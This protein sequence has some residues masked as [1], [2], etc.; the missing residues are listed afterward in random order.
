MSLPKNFLWG[1]AVAAH[2]IEGGLKETSKGVS[3]AD[4]VTGGSNIQPRIITDGIIEGLY[5]PDHIAIDFYHHYKE[6]IALF[7]EMG[8]KCFRT[9]IAWTRIFPKG[10]EKEPNEEGLKFYDDVFDELLKYKIELIITLSHFEMPYHLAKEYGGF[11]NRKTIDFFVN[12]AKICFERYKNK[13]KYWIPFNEI[14]IQMNTSNDLFG[15]WDSGVKFTKFDDPLKYMYQCG[16]YELIAFAKVVKIAHEINPNMLIGSMIAMTPYYPYSC[17]PEEQTL[18][19]EMMHK[20]L[21]WSDVQVRGYLPSYILKLFERK[22]WKLDFTDEDIKIL[23]EGKADYIA[24]SYYMSSTLS[25][26]ETKDLSK[27]VD[28]S[29]LHSVN[30]PYIKNSDWGWGID[31]EGLRYSLNLI[32]ERYELPIFI[33]ENGLGAFDVKDEKNQIHDKYRIEYL[34]SHIK[35]MKKAALYDGVELIGYTTWGP[36]DIISCG[37]GEMKKRYGFIYVDKNDDGTESLKRYK[38]DSFEWYKKVILSNGEEL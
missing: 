8:F 32:Y 1:G 15:W 6:D 33:L 17:K 23:K 2:Q 38:K 29:T 36:I 14:N 3:I 37:T 26:T 19:Q 34:S 11:L 20:H 4:V 18:A 25:S 31:P 24:I 27:S 5:Y 7:A 30:N 22:K 28:N 10:D 9:S 12:Y 13:V 21:F 35:S 16:L